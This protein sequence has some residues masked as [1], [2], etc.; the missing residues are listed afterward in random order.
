MPLRRPLAA[1]LI[2]PLVSTAAAAQAPLVARV[3]PPRVQAD[4]G[5]PVT[6]A[7]RVA[8]PSPTPAVADPLL[9]RGWPSLSADANA[10]VGRGASAVRLVA[11]VIP[12][13]TPAG[14][15]VVRY[16]LRAG[17]A[18]AM[19]SVIV[20][21]Q[22]RRALDVTV[23]DAPRFAVTGAEYH[24]GFRVTNRG[25]GRATVRIAAT[26]TPGF[27]ARPDA[28]ALDLAAGESRVV[29]VAVA[30]AAAATAPS[31]RVTLSASGDGVSATATARVEL[32]SRSARAANA[33]YA[34][35]VRVA[36][37][38]GSGGE[39]GGGVPAEVYASGP[40]TPNGPRVDL[41]YRGRGAAAPQLGEQE[42][43]S[44]A[45]RG[46]RGEVRLGDQ[47]WSLSP[48]TTPGRA[49]YGAGGRID[50]GAVWLEGFSARNRFVPNSERVTAG[51]IG[52]GGRGASLAA[53]YAASGDG[54]ALS[55]RGRLAPARGV[56]ADAEYGASGEGR[57]AY[58]HVRAG[59]SAAWVDA[60]AIGADRG[61]AGE[62][63]GRS[64]LQASGGARPAPWL[65]VRGAYERERRRD[66]VALALPGTELRSTTA[67][68][69]VTVGGVITVERRARERAGESPAGA[70]A[71]RAE[72][73]YAS[74]TLRARRWVFGGGGEAGEVEDERIGARSPYRRAWVRAG[75]TIAGQAV[76]AGIERTTGAS[77][78]SGV[79]QDRV[80]ANVSATVQATASTRL[81]L[82]AQAG[83][84]DWMERA[85]GL[86]D[87]SVEQRLPGGHSIRLRVRAFPWAE[88]GR[89]RP[90]VYLDYAV[91]LRVPTGR[92]RASGGVSGRVVDQETGRPVPDVLVRVGD[93]AVVTDGNGRWAVVGLPPGGYTVEID[94][95]SAGVGRVVVRPDAL[96]V[97]VAGGETHAVEVGVSRSA[98][99]SGRLIVTDPEE[100]ED[101]I[102]GV[103]VELRSGTERRRRMTD[104]HGAF[105]FSDL[106]PGDWTVT[107][108]GDGLPAH[109]ALDHETTAV[110]LE[111]G[112]ETEL[113]LRAVP[114]Q[115][116]LRIVAGG[117]L[118]LGGAAAR[119]SESVPGGRPAESSPS[120][121]P[122]RPSPVLPG[123]LTTPGHPVAPR[124][125]G[126]PLPA[127]PRPSATTQP[128]A[129]SAVS[130]DAPR[131]RAAMR[132]EARP[133]R[134]RG[135][136]GFSDWPNDSYVVREGDG[137]L[138]A[139]AW[140][141][142]R[143]GSLWPRLWL[144]NR[145]V[146]PA[147][148]RLRPG[149][150][151]LV[152]PPGPLTADERA[153]ARAWRESP[154]R[155]R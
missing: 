100:E 20:A 49:G 87:G 117:D 138:T 97:Q 124:L 36:L 19:D 90:L 59:G 29:R 141:V 81:S 102:G 69:G 111:P 98:R 105:L 67:S 54:N 56:A 47:F 118:V 7:F 134:Q 62:Q 142:Y 133:W 92:D 71:R 145:D 126:R 148:D 27:A 106:P 136:S 6:A 129:V 50:A 76:S 70:W 58:G 4:P 10:P 55:L 79:E 21:V 137:S 109:H 113:T 57:A 120:P 110:A 116:A 132:A 96:K 107:V 9:P 146:L 122:P 104:A 60:R 153:A 34:L 139:I 78:E 41:F 35:P 1:L 23:E 65:A 115:R 94:P 45:V 64:L 40:I 154:A 82:L 8:N 150:E 25:N 152:P 89:R 68:G 37:R 52:V 72:T 14:R 155:G 84:T 31:H 143:D 95:V 2:A 83:A 16:R 15:Y 91:P 121:A 123:L 125:A 38:A 80:A 127:P 101:G 32:V 22:P 99:V 53:N 135:E 51:T 44:L 5:A 61:F 131:T 24:A 42:Q 151:L 48:L 119:G 77:V 103:V 108:A 74:A 149:V 144:A 13:S 85:D 17:A 130:A 26:A 12:R 140:L 3:G 18:S 128:S 63:R 66:T 46:R 114:R 11:T 30:T 39:G 88:P 93:R 147:P 43:L 28:R 112:G 86:V 75:G 33:A 73:W